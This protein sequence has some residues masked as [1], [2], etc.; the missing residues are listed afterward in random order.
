MVYSFQLGLS[1][2]DAAD[3]HLGGL[4]GL[5]RFKGNRQRSASSSLNSLAGRI[6]SQQVA[7]N[8]VAASNPQ[9]SFLDLDVDGITGLAVVVGGGKGNTD[10]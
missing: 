1:R 9:A 7:S 2:S 10:V 3:Q 5:A 8:E 4:V 6:S